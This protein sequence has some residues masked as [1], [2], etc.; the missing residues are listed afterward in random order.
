MAWVD[1]RL[2]DGQGVVAGAVQLEERFLDPVGRRADRIELDDVVDLAV[3]R[4]GVDLQRRL[5]AGR[6]RGQA[7]GG[8]EAL[9]DLD[10]GGAV[11]GGRGGEAGT[12]GLDDVGH[13]LGGVVDG[14]GDLTGVGR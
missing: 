5:V 3:Q 11:R 4:A 12:K 7:A 9:L 14:S 2:R 1:R 13:G 6:L 8:P 10:A